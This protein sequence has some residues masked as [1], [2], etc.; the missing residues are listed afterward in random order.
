MLDHA[1]VAHLQAGSA[2]LI[3]SVA[4]DGMPHA[5]RSWGCT[6]LGVDQAAGTATVRL[7]LPGADATLLENLAT[8]GRVSITSADVPTLRSV[9]MKGRVLRTEAATEADLAKAA[10]YSD[11]FFDDIHRTDGEPLDMLRGWRPAAFAACIVEVDQLFDQ[12]PGPSAGSTLGA[13]DR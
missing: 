2:L 10:Q 6:V 5:S 12:T 8:T 1:T 7:V 4:A 11:D 3:G 13:R 9:Q